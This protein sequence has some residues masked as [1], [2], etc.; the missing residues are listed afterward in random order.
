M[1]ALL[2]ADGIPI[3]S[4]G[5]GP[6][7]YIQA[8]GTRNGAYSLLE[9]HFGCRWLWP[10]EA[11]GEVL[12]NQK[13]LTLQPINESDEP[14]IAQ[15]GI[16]NYYPENG[17][18]AYGRRQQQG[19]MPLLHRSYS[20]F[21]K[22][23]ANSGAWFDAMKLGQSIELNLGHSYGDYWKKYGETHPEYFALQADGTRNQVRLGASSASRA[24]LDVSNPELI[25][26]IADE[27]IA[28]FD[29]DPKLTSFSIAP[30]DGSYPS[31]CLCEVCRRLDP[32]NGDPVSFSIVDKT[33]KAS[34]ID[35]VSL[36]DRYVLFYSQIANIV[37]KKY[38]NKLLGAYAYS[39]Y[40][41]PPLYAILAPNVSLSYVG[42]SYF[43][44]AQRQ[45]DLH[46]WDLWARAANQLQLRPNALLGNYG[47]AANYA[48]KL[49]ADIK[50]AYQ[51]GMIGTDFDSLTHDWA[52]RG[53]NDYVLAKLLWDPS[54]DIDALIK[55]YCDTGF[56]A[57]SPSIQKY[58]SRLEDLTNEDA[59][60]ASA[61]SRAEDAIDPQS[62]K[63]MLLV[64]SK[65]Y[66]P[67]KLDELQSILDD[68][69]KKAAGDA[70]ITKRIEFLAQAIRY[71]K[72]D[73]AFLRV[74]F[75]P[76]SPDKKQRVLDALDARQKVLLDIYDNHFYAQSPFAVLY[77]EGSMF[78][79]YDWEPKN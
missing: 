49:G 59:K 57:A 69:K 72:V 78:K 55:D 4:N 79:E 11:G 22:K 65:T 5:T 17:A 18:N 27:A 50:H 56:G 20:D 29:A 41:S 44:D 61:M 42:L 1:A 30:N 58:F 14:A 70:E 66:T 19:V 39:V 25:Q 26:H 23:A 71:A 13:T 6:T 2:D 74:Y 68:A 43:N 21:L 10:A 48:H 40:S 34:R 9:R 31:F 3:K 32:P 24:H 75:S 37:A 51:T 62:Q 15:R 64:L 77:R 52:A 12:P 63:G 8:N 38:L 45:D 28:A 7:H 76:A 33:G 16:R 36:S 54:Q 67:E 46:S 53:L 60:A 73:T 47:I 35:Y